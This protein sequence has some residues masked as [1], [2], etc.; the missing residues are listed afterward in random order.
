M[1]TEAI[2]EYFEFLRRGIKLDIKD[3]GL[4]TWASV[5]GAHGMQVLM[6]DLVDIFVAY[7]ESLQKSKHGRDT[8]AIKRRKLF[9]GQSR[10]L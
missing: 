8:N 6:N 2:I 9:A 4:R 10:V 5:N 3:R 7:A 1:P